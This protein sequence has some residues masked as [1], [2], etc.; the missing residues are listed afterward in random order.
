MNSDYQAYL[1]RLQRNPTARHWRATLENVHTGVAMHFATE[2][3]LMRY[4]WH[5]IGEG[6]LHLENDGGLINQSSEKEPPA[7]GTDHGQ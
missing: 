3:V 2:E 7:E 5:M 6:R 4:L 1:L